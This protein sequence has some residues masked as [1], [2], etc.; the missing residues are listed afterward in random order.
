MDT[1]ERTYPS[2]DAV[3]LLRVR[4]GLR[5]HRGRRSLRTPLTLVFALTCFAVPAH[6]A[7]LYGTATCNGKAI[8]GFTVTLA[9]GKKKA[10]RVKDGQ[11]RVL[12]PEGK[13]TADYDGDGHTRT[14]RSFS[15]PRQQNLEFCK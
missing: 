6:A 15:S 8:D 9:N 3:S 14:I 11:Y 12:L 5:A 1:T 13:Y 10:I 2:P 4:R 7:V